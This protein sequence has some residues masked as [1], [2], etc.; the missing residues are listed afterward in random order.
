MASTVITLEPH[1]PASSKGK[2]TRN[3]RNV[4]VTGGTSFGNVK[5]RSVGTCT[6][7]SL[8]AVPVTTGTSASFEAVS[9]APAAT[10]APATLEAASCVPG[11]CVSLEPTPAVTSAPGD[12]EDVPIVSGTSTSR[13]AAPASSG[14]PELDIPLTKM[15]SKVPNIHNTG[16]V[17]LSATSSSSMEIAPSSTME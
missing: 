7:T 13:Q 8:E 16:E 4:N 2:L 5:G 1:A 3:R 9:A 12:S 10:G 6:S 14:A 11:A 17:V 15:P